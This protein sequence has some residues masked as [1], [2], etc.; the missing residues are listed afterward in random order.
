MA[1]IDG[2]NPKK[3][4]LL[5]TIGTLLGFSP[6]YIRRLLGIKADHHTRNKPKHTY[7]PAHYK[8][9]GCQPTDDNATIKKRYRELAKQYHPDLH[10]S[11]NMDQA[12][13]E[14][15]IQKIQEINLAYEKIKKERNI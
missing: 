8:I 4:E 10:E 3:T 1:R 15:T 6:S 9:L 2:L 5:F 11:Q 7:T 12:S 14:Y 13:K